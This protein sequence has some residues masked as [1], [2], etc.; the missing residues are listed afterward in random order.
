MDNMTRDELGSA[1][2]SAVCHDV[3]WTL[4]SKTHALIFIKYASLAKKNQFIS[5]FEKDSSL[6]KEIVLNGYKEDE[7]LPF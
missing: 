5:W 1:Y 3:L 2:L 6:A 7:D 4:K